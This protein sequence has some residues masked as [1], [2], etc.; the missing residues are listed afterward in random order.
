MGCEKNKYPKVVGAVLSIKELR[1][2][3]KE[4]LEVKK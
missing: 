3:G 1:R 2:E 4:I